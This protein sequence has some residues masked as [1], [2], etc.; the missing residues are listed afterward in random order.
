MRS[1]VARERLIRAL[2]QFSATR[3]SKRGGKVKED[4]IGI[5]PAAGQGLRLGLPYPKELYPIIKDNH[6]KPVAQHILE[7]MTA[8][9]VPHVVFVVNETK[10][11]LMGYFGDGH[12][13]NCHLSYVIQEDR[14]HTEDVSPGLSQA[15]DS[16]YH[17]ARGKT[18]AF[19]MAD[20]IIQPTNVFARM[21]QAMEP[22]DDVVLSLFETNDP[23]KFGMVDWNGEI[24]RRIVDKP[25][26][27]DLHHMWGCI[28]WRPSF[29]DHLHACLQRHSTDFADIMNRAIQDGMIFRG[30]ALKNGTYLDLGTYDAIARLERE[31]RV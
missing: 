21:M 27:T 28:L 15:L 13:F 26:V 9:G 16:A 29:T 31:Y 19:G 3:N 22:N 18:V 6:Y 4:V 14:G 10:H 2:T 7:N 20:T 8:A 5:I 25:E 12:R 23:E 17:L 1:S 24:V 11:Q 30:L